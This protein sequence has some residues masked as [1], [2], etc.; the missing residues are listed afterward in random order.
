MEEQ[1]SNKNETTPSRSD[2]EQCVMQPAIDRLN[3]RVGELKE[4]IEE[5]KEQGN[6]EHWVKTAEHTIG[7]LYV[8]I[9]V[10]DLTE[11]A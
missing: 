1:K 4:Q 7:C 8:A 6:M 2:L 5:L 9:H 3:E 11:A 10:L